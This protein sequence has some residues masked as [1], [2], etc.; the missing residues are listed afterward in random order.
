MCALYVL[1]L[2]KET[3]LIPNSIH[4]KNPLWTGF[5]RQEVFFV[6][7]S[8]TLSVNKALPVFKA[9]RTKK[10]ID[11]CKVGDDGVSTYLIEY[12]CGKSVRFTYKT[13]ESKV[14]L[15]LIYT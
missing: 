6:D 10:V 15:L 14:V 7:I 13:R 12:I 3:C 9:L 2:R 4:R 8:N 5:A 1:S 11:P